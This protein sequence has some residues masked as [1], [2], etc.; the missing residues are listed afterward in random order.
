MDEL[1]SLS[2][3]QASEIVQLTKREAEQ[4]T[5]TGRISE[6]NTQ[7]VADSSRLTSEVNIV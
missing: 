3:D 5:F 2:R 1:E 4:L 7:L 6:K